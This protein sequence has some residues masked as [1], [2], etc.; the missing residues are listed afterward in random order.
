MATQFI[1]RERGPIPPSTTPLT[2]RVASAPRYGVV[3]KEVKGAERPT[4]K[5]SAYLAESGGRREPVV[6]RNGRPLVAF[7]ATPMKATIYL[8]AALRRRTS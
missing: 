7:G 5:A 1:R 2:P 4:F 8:L 3:V 6:S